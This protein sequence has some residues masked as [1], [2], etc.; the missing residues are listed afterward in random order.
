MWS[1]ANTPILGSSTDPTVG[2]KYAKV[3][4]TSTNS[5]VDASSANFEIIEGGQLTIDKA[6]SMTITDGAKVIVCKV[7]DNPM[8]FTSVAYPVD[9]LRLPEWF[10]KLRRSIDIPVSQT[11]GNALTIENS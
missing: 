9:E 8:G 6:S 5:T 3:T 1:N 10:K 4:L 11:S 7:K 2:G